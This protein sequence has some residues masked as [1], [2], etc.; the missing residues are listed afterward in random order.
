M[1]LS[2]HPSLI[3]AWHSVA[4]YYNATIAGK[5]EVNDVAWYVVISGPYYLNMFKSSA[6]FYPEPK[7]DAANIKDYVA[8]YKVHIHDQRV[9]FRHG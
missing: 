8:F 4:S 5:T 1:Q 7:K 9:R 2:G 6:R 3:R